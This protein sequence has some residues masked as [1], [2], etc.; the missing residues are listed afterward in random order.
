[1]SAP[2]HPIERLVDLL[3]DRLG[4]AEADQ[5]REHVVGCAECRRELEWLTAGR[6][7]ARS[8][9][10]DD[11]TPDDLRA[12]VA[13]ALDRIDAA[14]VTPRAA[15]PTRR[16]LWAGLAAAAALTLYVFAPWR[17]QTPAPLEA[18]R[19]DYEAVRDGRLPLERRSSDAAELERFFR[20]S[21]R[22]APVRVIDL[23]MMGWT[24][25]GG[26]RRQVGPRS[27]A[28]YAYR[29]TT[30]DRLVCQMYEGRLADLPAA[31]ETRR[32][33]GFDF[34]VYTRRGVTLVFWQEGE[35]VCVLAADLPAA[36]V[37]AL[38]VAKAM[39]PA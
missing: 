29:S 30:G 4:A 36:E 14:A 25:E 32:E 37:V 1:M 24:L 39:A 18:A 5:V 34:Q 10:R 12:A 9:R 11:A 27:H 7:A 35:L 21:G 28:L 19:A 16:A 8:A 2:G 13:T 26:A 20:E 38:A 6:A 15:Q 33:N 3:D 31:D 22:G 17:P 23:G